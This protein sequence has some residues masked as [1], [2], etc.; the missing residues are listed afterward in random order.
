MNRLN[1]KRRTLYSCIVALM[2]AGCGAHG[3]ALTPIGQPP[4]GITNSRFPALRTLTAHG[5]VDSSENLTG[6]AVVTCKG[7]A[8]TSFTARGKA[9]GPYSGTFSASGDYHASRNGAAW[10]EESFTIN[11]GVNQVSGGIAM[12]G[13]PNPP[14]FSCP[15]FG[16]VIYVFSSNYGSGM[17]LI[18][19]AKQK[20]AFS[21]ELAGL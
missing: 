10:F 20:Y 14:V 4:L 21:E 15:T 16:P 17:A 7:D 18:L 11:S 13:Y 9:A 3:Q 8:T 1:L 2:L 12:G 6:R 5:Y 19:I